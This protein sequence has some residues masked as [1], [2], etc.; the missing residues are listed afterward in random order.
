MTLLH[1]VPSTETLRIGDTH[2][3]EFAADLPSAFPGSIDD[4]RIYERALTA[5]EVTALA[6][7][8]PALLNVNDRLTL[9]P[10]V[11]TVF[12]PT[13]MPAAPAGTFTITATFTNTSDTSLHFPFF[14]VTE[15][16][17]DNLLLNADEGA[18]GISAILTPDID[19]DLFAPG[20]SMTVDFVIGLHVRERFTF[21]VDVLA[22]PE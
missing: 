22:F 2:L 13:P 19:D 16:S 4:V 18:Q 10:D 11:N 9:V 17:G 14:L 6:H 15:L 5:T 3:P 1:P 12:D 20:T 8:R 21:F 7:E